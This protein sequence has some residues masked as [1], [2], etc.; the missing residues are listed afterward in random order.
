MHFDDFLSSFIYCHNHKSLSGVHGTKHMSESKT[1]H[2]I[3][4]PLGKPF[5]VFLKLHTDQLQHPFNCSRVTVHYRLALALCQHKVQLLEHTLIERCPI[6]K[7]LCQPVSSTAT[8]IVSGLRWICT[9]ISCKT[10]CECRLQQRHEVT[11]MA[12]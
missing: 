2:E 3:P 8:P 1:V 11:G 7:L 10:A 9:D 5:A 4:G 6:I 12:D